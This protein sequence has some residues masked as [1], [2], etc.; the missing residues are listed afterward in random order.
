[1]GSISQ[2]KE[3]N[4]EE[5]LR[6]KPQ[7]EG[8]G[9]ER[10]LCISAASGVAR[11]TA[12]DIGEMPRQLGS[13]PSFG[14]WPNIAINGKAVRADHVQNLPNSGSIWQSTGQSSAEVVQT[15]VESVSSDATS[16]FDSES[17]LRG[18][19]SAARSNAPL[20]DKLQRTLPPARAG[21]QQEM[22]HPEACTRLLPERV[23]TRAWRTPGGG[24]DG[25]EVRRVSPKVWA[26]L[27]T[28]DAALAPP[29]PT[30][31]AE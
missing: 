22:Q 1:M 25:S 2:L 20:R 6:R 24:G 31:A 4:E 11:T 18:A 3:T 21:L 30:S 29:A 8:E 13:P 14:I 7:K 9:K 28:S 10:N 23:F 5:R 27:H 17:P 26:R 15:K 16:A 19:M 12:A